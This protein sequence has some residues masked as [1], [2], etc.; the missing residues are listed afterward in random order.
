MPFPRPTLTTLRT[1][2]GSDISSGLPGTD[3]LLRFSNLNIVGNAV[4]G[5]AYLHYGYIDWI[6][7]QSNPFTATDE[8]LEAWAALKKVFRKGAVAAT[9]TWTATGTPGTDTDIPAGSILVR[10]DGYTYQTTVDMQVG[11]GGSVTIPITAILPPIDPINNPTGNGA[12]GTLS[13]EST[14]TLET[15]I[16]FVQSSGTVAASLTPG[17]DIELDDSLR[18]RMLFAYQSPPQGGDSNDFVEWALDVPGV[19]RAWCLPNGFGAGTVVLYVMLDGSESPFNG[20]PQGSNG[21]S[22]FDQGPGNLPRGVVAVGDQLAVANVI[23][24]EQPVTAL[25]FVVSPI[26][27]PINFTISGIEGASV[28][29][30]AQIAATISGIFVQSGAPVGAPGSGNVN[31]TIDLSAIES[32]IAAVPGTAGFVIQSPSTNITGTL[33]QLP[34]LGTV[35]YVT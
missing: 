6:S 2:V 16:P 23:V 12:I 10:G 7:L 27:D 25:L 28:A 17:A 19:T 14:L 18:T 31:A 5:L 30:K 29:T 11:A 3:G 24:T 20:F 1:E 35:D 34:T 22:E 4:A 21:V 8:F 26:A 33:G 15:A 32:A 13:V 9:G